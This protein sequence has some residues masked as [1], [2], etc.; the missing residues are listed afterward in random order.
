V[1]VNAAPP[2][3]VTFS[4]VDFGSAEIIGMPGVSIYSEWNDAAAGARGTGQHLLLLNDDIVMLP[5]TARALADALDQ[6]PDCGLISVGHTVPA[7]SPGAVV[8]VSHQTGDRR[9]FMQWCFIARADMWQD[10]DSRYR[11]WYGDDDLIWKMTAA[12]HEVGVLQGVGVSHYVSTTSVQQPW[13][14]QAAGEDGQL[15]A[16]EH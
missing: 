5:G 6:N 1:Y 15:W 4:D 7:V 2:T 8:R 10:V 9:S 3:P 12:G 13:T 14:H 11:I 16:S